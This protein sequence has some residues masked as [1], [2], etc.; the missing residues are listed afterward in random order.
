VT[1]DNAIETNCDAR[2]TMF[3]LPQPA[4]CLGLNARLSPG[5]PTPFRH[6][7]I[8]IFKAAT[9][10]MPRPPLSGS[11]SQLVFTGRGRLPRQHKCERLDNSFPSLLL[12]LRLFGH[13]FVQNCQGFCFLG[14]LFCQLSEL[15]AVARS[16]TEGISML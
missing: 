1:I 14:L 9:G 2:R 3:I 13:V 7:K 10:T 16:L 8:G 15:F 4:N 11:L 5:R 6:E 12:L